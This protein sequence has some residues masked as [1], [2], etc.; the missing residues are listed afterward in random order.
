[1]RIAFNKYSQIIGGIS[2]RSD[3]SM[4]WWNRMPVDEVIR[5]NRDQYFKRLGI[6]PERVVAGGIAHGTHAAI[7]G[8]QEAGKYLLN[9]DALVTNVPNLFLTITTADCMPVFCYDPITESL[10]IIH[11]GWRGLVGGV[12]ENT[13]HEFHNSYGSQPESLL[14]VIGPHIKA[15]HYEVGDEVATQFAEKNIEHRNDRLYAKLADEAEARLR[16]LGVKNISV[17]SICTYDDIGRF[18]SVRRDKAEPM[19]GMVAYIAISS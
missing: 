1:M 9:T 18:Y 14:I 12:L 5:K 6:D 2:E 7:I 16:R 8:E 11:A 4:V 19:Q 17:N 15:C 13:I 3:G 10:G